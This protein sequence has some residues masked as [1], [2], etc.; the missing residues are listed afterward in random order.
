MPNPIQQ[1]S[2]TESVQY[3][4]V[5]GRNRPVQHVIESLELLRFFHGDQIRRLFHNA[6]VS[7]A[8]SGLRHTVQTSR[9]RFADS[10]R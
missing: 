5:E 10:P 3:H 7:V 6:D 8:R 2:N 9:R 1:F 4:P